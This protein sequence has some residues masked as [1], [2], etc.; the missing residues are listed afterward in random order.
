MIKEVVD[1]ATHEVVIV[2]KPFELV[3]PID[4]IKCIGLRRQNGNVVD[5]GFDITRNVVAV[6][7]RNIRRH[8]SRSVGDNSNAIA[9]VF[10]REDPSVSPRF[11]RDTEGFVS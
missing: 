10:G 2:I 5:N 9:E 1:F 8:C 4:I 11:G 7:G 3:R 6:M